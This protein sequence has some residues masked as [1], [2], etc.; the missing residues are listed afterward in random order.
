MRK[1]SVPDFRR[2]AGVA[3]GI[4]NIGEP[5][6]TGPADNVKNEIRKKDELARI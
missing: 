3:E 1:S 6:D 4:L 5:P 2:G